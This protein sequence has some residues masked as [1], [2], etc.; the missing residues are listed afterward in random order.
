MDLAG[1]LDKP[2]RAL[3]MHSGLLCNHDPYVGTSSR[4]YLPGNAA[5][6]ADS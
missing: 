2:R 4:G 3:K 6:G 1:N 5:A